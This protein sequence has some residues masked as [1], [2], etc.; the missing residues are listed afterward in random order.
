MLCSLFAQSTDSRGGRGRIP[1][2]LT[3]R[4]RFCAVR[5]ISSLLPPSHHAHSRLFF[6]VINSR[7]PPSSALNPQSSV[8]Q[9]PRLIHSRTLELSNFRTSPSPPHA[10]S[11]NWTPFQVGTT[12]TCVRLRGASS[13][14]PPT[15]HSDISER[16]FG[17]QRPRGRHFRMSS[18]D[19][20]IRLLKR[21]VRLIGK[22]KA[23]QRRLAGLSRPEDG[24]HGK[25]TGTPP[26]FRHYRSFYHDRESR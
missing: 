12:R 5:A 23:C 6:V 25:L 20:R 8:H 21:K 2:S 24:D 13:W 19:M 15:T 14:F 16:I 22:T 17:A 18:S 26:H 7:P 9:P 10:T 11:F 1:V 3:C 4:A